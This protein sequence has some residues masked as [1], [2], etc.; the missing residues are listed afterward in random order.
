MLCRLHWR[1]TTGPDVVAGMATGFGTTVL[2][3][4]LFKEASHGLSEVLPAFVAILMMTI[5]VSRLAILVS[6][7]TAPVA[8]IPAPATIS[9]PPSPGGV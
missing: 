1:G 4:A 7:L 8:S 3:V 6:R 2:W 9:A 5:L